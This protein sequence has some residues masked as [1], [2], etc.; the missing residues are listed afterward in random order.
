MWDGIDL[1]HLLHRFRSRRPWSRI[2]ATPQNAS[3]LVREAFIVDTLNEWRMRMRT[4]CAPAQGS[5]G[6]PQGLTPC[7]AAVQFTIPYSF[8][9]RSVG[10]NMTSRMFFVFERSIVRRSID[11]ASP[12][13]GGIPYSNASRNASS[14]GW[15]SLSPAFLFFS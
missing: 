13:A 9:G 4:P 2:G 6:D 7:G 14:L 3:R 15:A 1:T 8:L 12:P 10:K 5:R 11:I